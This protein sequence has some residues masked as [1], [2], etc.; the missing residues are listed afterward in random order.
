MKPAADGFAGWSI[1]RLNEGYRSGAVSPVEVARWAAAEAEAINARHGTVL[2][3]VAA[4][5]ALAAA[6][7]SEARW[8][9]SRPLGPLDGVPATIKN[10]FAVKGW[11][12][13]FCSLT[14]APGAG[15]QDDA[16]PVARLREAGA[17][18]LGYTAAPE[19]SW[20]LVTDSARYGVT[21]NPHDATR[22]AGG[23]SGGAAVAAAAGLAPLNVASDA[24]GSI[25]IPAAFC[26]VFGMKP[27]FGTV[28]AY[29]AGPLTHVGPLARRVADAARLLD[30]LGRPDRR[31]WYN[32]PFDRADAFSHALGRDIAGLRVA[33]APSLCGLQADPEVERRVA[34]GVR[35][36]EALGAEIAEAEPD[37]PDPRRVGQVFFSGGY[38]ARLAAM[39]D[40]ARAQ[41][42]PGL[43][44]LA[45]EA[46]RFTADDIRQA[47]D[48][49]Y[50]LGAALC[51]FFM[52]HDVLVTP[53]AAV[54]ALPLGRNAPAGHLE[55]DLTG[56]SVF[57]YTF[58]L[59]QNPAASLPC[60]RTAAGLPVGMQIVG[61][62]FDDARVLAVA[63]ALERA[64]VDAA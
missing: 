25:R 39:D 17:V 2:T 42:D 23:S 57:T 51:A 38:R 36:L 12:L 34:A 43:R 50:R 41:V 54:P 53:T 6:R 18:L 24:A 58:N 59:A 60:G 37:L 40:A 48:T 61:R 55:H 49:R 64:G 3:H 33:Y 47:H 31:D 56:W 63:A 45:E 29:P 11:P 14:V 27:T 30:V 5:E 52:R 19:F 15:P 46:A 1:A 21:R 10:L 7:A 26:G 35:H 62:K 16:P 8:R 22:S 4:Q 32:T 9:A 13:D 28:A 44:R 20:K